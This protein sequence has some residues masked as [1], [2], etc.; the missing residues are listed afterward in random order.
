MLAFENKYT[1]NSPFQL[2]R[3]KPISFP[4]LLSI[5]YSGQYTYT[6]RWI[7]NKIDSATHAVL[8]TID[9]SNNPSTNLSELFIEENT[10]AY[11]LYEVKYEVNVRMA[12]FTHT[13][14]TSYAY[15]YVNVIP[16]GLVING[17]ENGITSLSIG[18]SQEFYLTPTSYSYDLDGLADFFSLVY[19]YYCRT[20]DLNSSLINNSA[21]IDLYTFKINSSLSIDSNRNCFSSATSGTCF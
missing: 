2:I 18:S 4:V 5:K 1:I 7:L 8:N 12:P 10:L 6:K 16:T 17:I 3:S 20:I 13:N 19:K 11:G 14:F 21:I 15:S 9:I